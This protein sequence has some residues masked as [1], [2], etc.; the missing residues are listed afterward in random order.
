MELKPIYS[1]LDS[2]SNAEKKSTYEKS[3][4]WKNSE[5]SFNWTNFDYPFPHTHAHYETFVIVEG[6]IIHKING[7]QYEMNPGDA[8]FVRPSDEHALYSPK[9]APVK[10]I[11]FTLK[12]EYA[13]ALMN[14][15]KIDIGKTDVN[16]DL[17]F[18]IDASKLRKIVNETILIQSLKKA[19]LSD[20]VMRCK[21]LFNELFGDFA[22]QK[23]TEQENTPEWVENLLVTLT[24]P[25]ISDM[26]I[27]KQLATSSNY[28]YS[29]M[30]RLFKKYTGY[31]IIEYIHMKK[32]EYAADLLSHSDKKILE[33]ASLLGYDSLSHFN[34]LFKRYTGLTPS[35]CRKA[36]NLS[37]FS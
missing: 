5:I 25:L 16:S 2:P 29:S 20:R 27:K 17:R 26:S 35:Q 14:L 31:T 34:H 10:T 3:S 11:N 15:F 9:N 33:I 6:K 13:N 28:S 8:C 21:I 4:P 32:I 23:F 7:K 1:I 18:R 36:G 24:D 37:S 30:I 22:K 12:S 19:S